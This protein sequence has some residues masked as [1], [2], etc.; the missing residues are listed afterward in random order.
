MGDLPEEFFKS[1]RTHAIH[2]TM[3]DIDFVKSLPFNLDRGPYISEEHYLDTQFQLLR[4]DL[5]YPLRKAIHNYRK[6]KNMESSHLVINS[7][8]FDGSREFI[9]NKLGFVFKFDPSHYNMNLFVNGFLLLFSKDNFKTF[10][11]GLV[12]KDD[13]E[14]LKLGILHVEMLCEVEIRPN[15][16]LSMGQFEQFY[17]PYNWT[18]K[19]IQ[20][21]DAERFP[22]KKYIIYASKAPS[23]PD[24]LNDPTFQIYDIDDYRFNILNNEEWPTEVYLQQE[25]NQF[26][27]FKAALTEKLALIR[28]VSGTGKTF[29]GQRIVKTL[30]EN[31]YVTGR[32]KN[33]IAI[34]CNNNHT[35]DHFL[36][37]ILKLTDKLIRIGSQ[38]KCDNLKKYSLK[39]IVK[40]HKLNI[41]ED[42]EIAIKIKEQAILDYYKKCDQLYT[43]ILDWNVLKLVVPEVSNSIFGD[44]WDF[45][46][47]LFHPFS[48]D[49]M[50]KNSKLQEGHNDQHCL[51]SSDIKIYLSELTDQVTEGSEYHSFKIQQHLSILKKFLEHF[52]SMLAYDHSQVKN[53]SITVDD[54]HLVPANQRWD[55]YYKWVHRIVK[56][57]KEIINPIWCEYVELYKQLDENRLKQTLDLFNGTHVIGLTTTG[58]VKNKDLLERLKPPIVI[59]EEGAET[60]EP[61]VV[62]SLTEHVQHLILIGDLKP[63]RPKIS[64]YNLAK[65]H[66][67]N[68]TLMER[69]INNGL[70]LNKLTKQFRLRPEIMS[71]IL[72]CITYSLECSEITKNLPNIIGITKN[73]Y[74]IEHKVVE[75]SDVGN[76]TNMHEAKFLIGVARYLTL[77]NYKSEDILILTT[78]KNQIHQIVKQKEESLLLKYVNVSAVDSCPVNECEIV[79]LS[80]VYSQEDCFWKNENRICTA[81]SKAKSGLYI[82]GNI[83]NLISQSDLWN[84]I[85]TSLLNQ[86]CYGSDLTLECS[87][88]KGTFSKVFKSEDFV[89]RKCPRPCLQ[90]LKCGH[91]CQSVCH[92]RDRDH[93]YVF[94]CKHINCRSSKSLIRYPLRDIFL[95]LWEY[96]K[97]ILYEVI[98]QPI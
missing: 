53:D 97:N 92:T 25:S 37:G 81:L 36:E 98:N 62:S 91:Y 79:L 70:P 64:S 18:L 66:N 96:T 9:G 71:L 35:L 50:L 77:Q 29:I 55:L 72:P 32:L 47:W 54:L 1:F 31:L 94:K 40:L 28:G 19:G 69:L 39:E 67:F 14:Y 4:E 2:P 86:K 30:L 58:A 20:Q 65:V 3:N 74:F 78:H 87:V 76:H 42:L 12:L 34:I 24:Y 68:Q 51:K 44:S 26:G 23:V 83:E 82:I 85:Y 61:Y 56:N 48:V 21:M 13:K 88:H 49:T 6:N 5:I 27:A 16:T 84:K 7:V 90:Q 8:Y 63:E 59:I 38:S 73:V 93:T 60:L 45:L 10:F 80:T 17:V 95:L 11:T 75:E 52:E 57:Y 22:L 89:T 15:T 33:P 41:D 46:N 43:G